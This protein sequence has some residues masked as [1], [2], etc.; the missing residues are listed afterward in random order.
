MPDIPYAPIDDSD[1]PELAGLREEISGLR[2]RL[3]NLHRALANCPPALRSFMV[4]SRFVRDECSLPGPLRELVI[5]AVARTLHSAYEIA[6]HEPIAI[7]LGV[8]PEQL[9]D[10]ERAGTSEQFSEG[11]RAAVTYAHELTAI[12]RVS[13]PTLNALRACF[14]A[15]EIFELSLIVGWYHLCH[16]VIETFGIEAETITPE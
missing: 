6:I 4:M 16:V 11:E 2:G 7:G 1:D 12:G 15:A 13:R 14:D 8:R 10:L 9:T 5:L 3:L